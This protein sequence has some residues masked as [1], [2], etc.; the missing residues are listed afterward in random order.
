MGHGYCRRGA[1]YTYKET[2]VYADFLYGSGL[3]SGLANT[4]ELA[5]YYPLNVGFTHIFH[6][7]QKYG[8][9]KFRFDVTNIFDQSY[10]LR[11]GTG[12]RSVRSSIRP[13]TRFFWRDQLDVLN[14]REHQFQGPL[15]EHLQLV[16]IRAWF[17]P[18]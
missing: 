1:S 3:R 9:L 18:G 7:P 4:D 16:R 11:S 2:A 10:Q 12:I 15:E 14:P 6:L 5:G 8:L 13:T 17:R